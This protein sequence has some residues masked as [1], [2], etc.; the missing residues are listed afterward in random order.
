MRPTKLNLEIQNELCDLIEKGNYIETASAIVGISKNTLYDW[1]KRGRRGK[2]QLEKGEKLN[3]SELP[4]I[5]FSDAVEKA[6]AIGE[7]KDLEI[8]RKA[9]MEDWK[10]SA[11]RLERRFPTKWGR[12]DKMDIAANVQSEHR[13]IELK[14]E[15]QI[16]FDPS[17]VELI[18]QL[19]RRQQAVEE[20]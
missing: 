4:F 18:R 11:W 7:A 13:E 6:F 19:W 20:T 14:I 1:L 12:K 10:A 17:S 2:E 3:K 9:A 5:D 15:K 16:E 8:I